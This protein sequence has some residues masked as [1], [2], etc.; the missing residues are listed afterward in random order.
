MSCLESRQISPQE[1]AEGA[2]L[3]DGDGQNARGS[4]EAQELDA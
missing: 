1:A 3:W 2:A 4:V